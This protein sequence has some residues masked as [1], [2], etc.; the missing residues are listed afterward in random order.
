MPNL[1]N[2]PE[3]KNALIEETEKTFGIRLV[4][5]KLTEEEKELA[6]RLFKEKYTM[7][8]FTMLANC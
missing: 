6:M 7:Q 8:D 1:P 3:L 2:E 4:R 5:G